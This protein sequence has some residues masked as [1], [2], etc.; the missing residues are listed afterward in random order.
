L[1]PVDS[2]AVVFCGEGINIPTSSC[3]GEEPEGGEME[4]LRKATVWQNDDVGAIAAEKTLAGR[5]D[6]F[7]N[8]S[9]WPVENEGPYFGLVGL[10]EAEGCFALS[11]DN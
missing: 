11:N 9:K 5:N 3:D 2:A 7:D 1:Q 10:V 8:G 4:A 6:E